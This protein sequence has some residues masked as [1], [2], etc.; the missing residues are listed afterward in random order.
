MIDEANIKVYLKTIKKKCPRAYRKRLL[1]DITHDV[2]EY[3][4]G[5]P[6]ATG[7]DFRNHFGEPE[8]FLS[9][10]LAEME[11]SEC[12]KLLRKSKFI[13]CIIAVAAVLVVAIVAIAAVCIIVESSQSVGY[14]YSEEISE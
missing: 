13:K 5:H 10:C 4:D 6:T 2:E 8:Q 12:E 11:D 14:Y 7:S 3:L 9:H 1:G